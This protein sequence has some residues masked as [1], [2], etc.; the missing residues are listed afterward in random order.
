MTT[1]KATKAA[2]DKRARDKW[3]SEGGSLTPPRRSTWLPPIPAPQ[4]KK[5]RGKAM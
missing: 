1:S 3:E 2:A 5:K 4:A